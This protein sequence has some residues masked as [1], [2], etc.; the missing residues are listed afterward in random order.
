MN[1][2]KRIT[3]TLIVL[4]AV[5]YIGDYVT[6]RYQIPPGRQ[7][8]GS[9]QVEQFTA[10][11]QKSGKIE[12]TDVGPATKVCVNSLFPQMGYSPCWYASRQTREMTNI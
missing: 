5:V 8:F 12:Y 11:K 4:L 7:T 1:A 9:V 2:L 6:V 3:V 10:F